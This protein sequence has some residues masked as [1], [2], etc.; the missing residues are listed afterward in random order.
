M[1]EG[2]RNAQERDGAALLI[3]PWGKESSQIQ[4]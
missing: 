3:A 1:E 4:E 2:E